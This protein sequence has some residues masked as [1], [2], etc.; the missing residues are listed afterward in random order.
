MNTPADFAEYDT[1]LYFT[2]C[3]EMNAIKYSFAAK[4]GLAGDIDTR[5]RKTCYGL[6]TVKTVGTIHACECCMSCALHNA[7][8]NYRLR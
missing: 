4:A 3:Q 7:N 5:V 1:L 8:E 6:H 2:G